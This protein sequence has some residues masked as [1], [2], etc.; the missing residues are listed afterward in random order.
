MEPQPELS[1][2]EKRRLARSILAATS[3]LRAHAATLDD[4]AL[5]YSLAIAEQAARET[6]DRLVYSGAFPDKRGLHEDD[7][8][9][10]QPD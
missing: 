8:K 4:A 10:V 5:S 3:R 9:W 2:G 7:A 1:S 6:V